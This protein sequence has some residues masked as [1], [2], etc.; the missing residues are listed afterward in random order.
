MV[1][2]KSNGDNLLVHKSEINTD[3]VELECD[4]EQCYLVPDD[5]DDSNNVTPFDHPHD[6]PLQA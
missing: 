3:K 6:S 2:V 4:G 5:G 1:R